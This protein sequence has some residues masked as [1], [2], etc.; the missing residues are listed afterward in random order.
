MAKCEPNAEDLLQTVFLIGNAYYLT[1]L[2]RTELC[3]LAPR[4]W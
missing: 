1:Q 4:K 2:T 3:L